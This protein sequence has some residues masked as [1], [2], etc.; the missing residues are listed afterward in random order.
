MVA[1]CESLSSYQGADFPLPAKAGSLRSDS[2]MKLS[3]RAQELLLL[4]D[5]KTAAYGMFVPGER[6]VWCRSL[7]RFLYL[8]GASDVSCLKGLETRGLIERPP[9][10]SPGKYVYQITEDGRARAEKLLEALYPDGWR[11]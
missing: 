4:V 9:I 8:F 1:S 7:K 2:T 3:I 11:P 6:D 10:D 5:E